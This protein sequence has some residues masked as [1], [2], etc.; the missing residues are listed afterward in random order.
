MGWITDMVNYTE[1]GIAVQPRWF[2]ERYPVIRERHT[3]WVPVRKL[4]YIKPT[5]EALIFMFGEGYFINDEL[6]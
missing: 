3:S 6:N 4:G 5:T 2:V 1:Q